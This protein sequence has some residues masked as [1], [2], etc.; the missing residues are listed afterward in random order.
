[1]SRNSLLAYSL[2]A[3]VLVGA[4]PALAQGIIAEVTSERTPTFLPSGSRGPVLSG[5]DLI[6][7]FAKPEGDMGL[8][9]V[10]IQSGH[11]LVRKS[12]IM[13]APT[14]PRPGQPRCDSNPNLPS[15]SQNRG[16]NGFDEK[17]C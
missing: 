5:R 2:L 1:M 16:R 14:G 7:R 11:V 8:M 15:N 9:G 6:G 4:V 13:F 3:S 17:H 12:A 10:D